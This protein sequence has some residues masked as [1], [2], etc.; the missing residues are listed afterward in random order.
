MKRL[1]DPWHQY[2]HR[3]TKWKLVNS[4]AWK[5][6]FICK[7][8]LTTATGSFDDEFT[9]LGLMTLTERPSHK[10]KVDGKIH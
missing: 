7:A 3:S 2:L 9:P 5:I 1:E 6:N 10:Y 8:I 4:I